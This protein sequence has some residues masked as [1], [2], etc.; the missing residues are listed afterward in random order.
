V[1]FPGFVDLQVNGYRGVAFTDPALTSQQIE[2][3][4]AALL[5]RGTVGYCPTLVSSPMKVYERNLPLLAKAC[6]SRQGAKVLGIH[7]EGPFI[8]PAE[9]PRGIHARRYVVPPSIERFER[10]RALA[11]DRIAILT[12]AP[13]VEGAVPL[14]RHIVQTTR[15]VVAIGHHSADAETIR[16]AVDAG[17]RACVHVGNGMADMIHRHHNPLWPVLADDALTGFFISDGHHLPLE[18]LRVCLRAKGVE[19]FI[20]TSDIVHLAGMAPGEYRFCGQKVV[21]ERN[22]RL[23]RKGVSTQAGATSDMLD[24]MN[25]M[26][27]LG[28]LSARELRRVGYDNPLRLLGARIEPRRLATAPPLHLSTASKLVGWALPTRIGLSTAS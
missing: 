2:A 5:R 25:V 9:G 22:G 11:D 3:V 7:L 27:A 19:R 10:L 1:K 28:E 14:I 6:G 13:E 15:T 18:M 26:A 8:H 20:V 12:L 21:L 16:R 24:C 4:S 23:H 17:A